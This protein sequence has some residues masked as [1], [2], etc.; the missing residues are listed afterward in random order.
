MI[1][2]I[3]EQCYKPRIGSYVVL[4]GIGVGKCLLE[5]DTFGDWSC[6]FRWPNPV[7]A[8]REKHAIAC[9]VTI[10]GKTLQLRNGGDLYVR[11]R[12]EW[13]MDGEPNTHCGGWMMADERCKC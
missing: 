12:I 5:G 7:E 8:W 10:T 11:V 4:D 9:N 6:D 3:Y 2:R 1:T 13:V